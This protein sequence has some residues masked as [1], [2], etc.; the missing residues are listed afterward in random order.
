M[1]VFSCGSPMVNFWVSLSKYNN[2]VKVRE[3]LCF[4]LKQTIVGWEGISCKCV[5][6]G[7]FVHPTFYPDLHPE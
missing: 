6:V 3:R 7:F 1:S 4:L 2:L 5:K